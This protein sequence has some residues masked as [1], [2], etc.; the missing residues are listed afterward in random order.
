MMRLYVV[1]GQQR[2]QRPLSAGDDWYE[3]QKG[4]VLELD[5]DSGQATTAFEYVSPPE[6]CP[7]ENATILFK[8]GSV[9]GDRLYLCTQTEIMVLALPSFDRIAYVSLP[10]FNDVHHVLPTAQGTLLVANTGLDT[11][12]ELSLQGDVVRSWNVLGEDP[13][14]RFS[15]SIDYRRVRTTKPHLAH[16]NH[17]FLV[18]DEIWVTRFEQRDAICLSH[19]GRRIEI[20]LERVHDGVYHEGLVYFTTV[21]GRLVMADP[22]KCEVVEVIDLKSMHAGDAQLGWCRG[23]LLNGSTAWVGFS[24]I[25]PTK[26]RE[27]VGWVLHG[28]KRD[29]GTHVAE[30][31]LLRR[32]CL[33]EILVEPFGLSAVFGIFPAFGES[34]PGHRE[35]VES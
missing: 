5:T 27:N 1:G 11:V 9:R 31:D 21:D 14:A 18:D 12:V 7:E 22:R 33:T 24:R 10:M 35:V 23:I 4:L 16:P 26:F 29:F 3:Y 2:Q 25:R 6:V 17:V 13:W 28:F 32:E 15:P 8:S 19:P 30:Y 34:E 20:G